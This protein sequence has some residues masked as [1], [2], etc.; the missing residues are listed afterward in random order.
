[1]HIF[2]IK[3]KYLKNVLHVIINKYVNTVHY[4]VHSICI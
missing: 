1:M 3:E 2:A 4:F